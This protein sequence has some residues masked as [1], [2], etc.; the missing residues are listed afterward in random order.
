MSFSDDL[1]WLWGLVIIFVVCLV[2]I[3]VGYSI[4]FDWGFDSGH[5]QQI[6]YISEVENN[7]WIWRPT[8]IRLISIEPTFSESDTVWYF[9]PES[10]EITA[11]AILSMKTHEK[12][13]VKYEV[14][15]SAN[16][17]DYSSRV[18]MT[19]IRPAGEGG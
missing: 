10:S 15:T 17:W 3:I 4:F 14:W 16:H 2:V 13:I 8:E 5:G 7:G 11:K 12:V 19:D 1:G 18:I 9:A 6:G